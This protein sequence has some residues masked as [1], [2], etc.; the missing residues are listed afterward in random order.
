[1]HQRQRSLLQPNWQKFIRI[2]L[3]Y[4]K[5]IRPLSANE[6]SRCQEDKTATGAGSCISDSAAIHAART[7]HSL[8]LMPKHRQRSYGI[9]KPTLTGDNHSD[10]Y[11]SSAGSGKGF[12]D[13]GIRARQT[14]R[15]RTHQSLL[16]TEN[17]YAQTWRY[18]Q[19]EQALTENE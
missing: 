18:Q 7:T 6:V 9:C 1:M 17:W 2:F 5:D 15:I 16:E 10:D 3:G 13:P 11:S 19:L 8:P 4:R 14:K 12:S